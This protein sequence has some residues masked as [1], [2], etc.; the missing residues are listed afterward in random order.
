MAEVGVFSRLQIIDL[1]D[2]VRL[3]MLPAMPLSQTCV[4]TR[5]TSLLPSISKTRVL[6]HDYSANTIAKTF[7]VGKR[8]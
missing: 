3:S 7:T 6:F 8:L 1:G 2:T 5:K 4:L